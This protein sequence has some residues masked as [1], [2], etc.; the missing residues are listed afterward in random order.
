MVVAAR[1]SRRIRAVNRE[2]G[3]QVARNPSVDQSSARVLGVPKLP[4][5]DG[6]IDTASNDLRGQAII[7]SGSRTWLAGSVDNPCYRRYRP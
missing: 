7:C 2:A 3:A 5:S 6:D 1:R 4:R